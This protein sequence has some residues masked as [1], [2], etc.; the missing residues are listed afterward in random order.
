MTKRGPDLVDPRLARALEHPIRSDILSVL[1]DGPSSPAR[2]QRRL[3]NVSLNLVSHHMKVLLE[4]G[5]V[6]LVET[7]TRKGA[8]EHI[9]KAVGL[10]ILTLREW[11]GLGLKVRRRIA[12]A[13]LR[14]LSDD[15]AKALGAGKFDTDLDMHISRTPLNLDREGWSEVAA[16]LERALNEVLEI[17]KRS[18]QRAESADQ[19]PVPVTVAIM[20]FPS[21]E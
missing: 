1:R 7:V 17:G 6:E 18:S 10:P 21:A 8:R 3:D 14:R 12:L 15:L 9:Y 13:V 5:C 19:K 20:H 11:Q 4:L 2:I 16:V